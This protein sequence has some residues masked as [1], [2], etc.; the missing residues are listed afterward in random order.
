MNTLHSSI[1]SERPLDRRDLPCVVGLDAIGRY[2]GVTDDP[3]GF[4]AA[5]ARGDAIGRDL[6]RWRRKPVPGVL[7]LHLNHVETWSSEPG[8]EHEVVRTG[9]VY[10]SVPELDSWNQHNGPTARQWWA[11]R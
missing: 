9:E 3:A 2:L 4:V 10:A 11:L 1:D 6:H 7:A 5:V 8:R